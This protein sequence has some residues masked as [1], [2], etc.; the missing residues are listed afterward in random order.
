MSFRKV[1]WAVIGAGVLAYC[2]SI[3]SAATGSVHE[4]DQAGVAGRRTL[5]EAH[6]SRVPTSRIDVNGNCVRA[7]AT[8]VPCQQKMSV[9]ACAA[10][11][12]PPPGY[13]TTAAR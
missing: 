6:F 7:L 2:R 13:C 3:G 12:L 8:M 4:L 9:R 1:L 5:G 11:P 10:I